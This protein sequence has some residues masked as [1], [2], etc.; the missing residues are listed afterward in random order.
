MRKTKIVCDTNIWYEFAKGNYDVSKMKDQNLI[1]THV[2]ITELAQT[3]NMTE[4]PELFKRT[5]IALKDNYK[6]IIKTNPY[7]Y[8]IGAFFYGFKPDQSLANRILSGFDAFIQMDL[9]SIPIDVLN[10]TR[11]DIENVVSVQKS[12]SEPINEG[13]ITIRQN[14]KKNGGK[15]KRKKI[16]TIDSWKQFISD[17]VL[18]YSREFLN[19]DYKININHEQWKYFEFIILTFEEYFLRLEISANRKFDKNDWGDLLNLVYVQPGDKYWTEENK[20]NT[21]FRENE[22]LSKYIYRKN[23]T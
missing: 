14:I 4:N 11:N 15:K 19:T 12:I 16:N 18:S 20:W 7:E 10:K 21:I 8:L 3:P 5:L 13:L 6:G 17:T 2:S 23:T 22:T 9:N 1:G